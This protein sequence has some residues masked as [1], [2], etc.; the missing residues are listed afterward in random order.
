ML[1]KY[2]LTLLTLFFTVFS[3]LADDHNF[4][5]HGFIAQGIINVNG[6]DFVNDDEELSTELTELGLNSSYRINN[7]IRLA[8][9]AVYLDGGNRYT[10][11]ARIDYL[12]VD[13]SAYSSSDWLVNFYL[14]RFKNY[15][16]LY[17]STRD[18]PFT[19]PTIVLPQTIY[20]DGFRDIAVGGDGLNIKVTHNS[21][22]FGDFDF[23]ISRG[24]SKISK[25]QTAL[26]LSEFATGDMDHDYDLQASLYWRPLFSPWRF[27]VALLDSEFSYD[28][29]SMDAFD[30]ARIVLQ[31]YFVN[32]LFE[33]ENWEFSGELLQERFVMDGFYFSGFHRDTIGQGYFVQ[34][35]YKINS[36][37]DFLLRYERFYGNKED[38]NGKKFSQ[39]T[40]GTI[41]N[42]FGYMNDITV[43]VSYDLAERLR[44]QLE[45]HQVKGTA[46][47]T[48]VVLPNVLLNDREKWHMWAVQLMYWF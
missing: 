13:W 5:V 22:D 20:F 46:R 3:T 24:T 2:S 26:I 30:H 21:D 37:L 16:W 12:L 39:S 27:G 43:G 34:G 23:N 47:L 31:R 42:Y 9:Q 17:S 40:Q 14:G 36:D 8:G 38:K 45:Y 4:Q 44:V 33:G 19:R 11:G 48:P 15:H 41:P 25:D 1:R 29:G 32:A 6:S 28:K 18:V 7:N 35:K 10:D